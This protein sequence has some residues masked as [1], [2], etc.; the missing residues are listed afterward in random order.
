MP[1]CVASRIPPTGGTTLVARQS[2]FHGVLNACASPRQLRV[3][4]SATQRVGGET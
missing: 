4:A 1:P 2:R 3:S